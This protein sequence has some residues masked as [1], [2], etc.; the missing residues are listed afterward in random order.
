MESRMSGQDIGFDLR[1]DDDED[2]TYAPAAYLQDHNVG[3]AEELENSEW[4]SHNKT[5]LINAISSLDDRS[6]DIVQSRWLDD[7]NKA[8]LQ[9]LADKYSVSA[10]RIRQIENNAMKKLRNALS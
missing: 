6:Q 3:P 1:D 7:D 4:E 2:A 9:E 5:R 10:E 8:T